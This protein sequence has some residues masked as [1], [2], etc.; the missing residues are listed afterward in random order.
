MAGSFAE[1]LD[2]IVGL[3]G[4][5]AVVELAG[6]LRAG[7]GVVAMLDA[8]KPRAVSPP[9]SRPRRSPGFDSR[10]R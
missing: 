10:P 7:M 3:A 6:L 5:Q 4:L 1:C 8:C 9:P 2:Q